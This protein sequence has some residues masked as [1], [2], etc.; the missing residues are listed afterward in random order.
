MVAEG[1]QNGIWVLS[2][3]V[4]AKCSRFCTAGDVVADISWIW[5]HKAK[6]QMFKL[7]SIGLHGIKANLNVGLQEESLTKVVQCCELS[8]T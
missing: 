4:I 6:I 3:V 1:S 8:T 7:C 2:F 5:I